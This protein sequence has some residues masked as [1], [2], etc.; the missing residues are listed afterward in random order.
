MNINHHLTSQSDECV[1]LPALRA[2][3]CRLFETKQLDGGGHLL[4]LRYY[5]GR[6]PFVH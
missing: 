3:T 6:C 2:C 4:H 5:L 1:Q